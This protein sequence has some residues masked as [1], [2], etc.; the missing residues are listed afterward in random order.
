MIVQFFC[1]VDYRAVN[2]AATVFHR[3]ERSSVHG[4]EFSNPTA[5]CHVVLDD[6]IFVVDIRLIGG[7]S[8]DFEIRACIRGFYHHLWDLQSRL[9]PTWTGVE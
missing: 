4:N 2:N 3:N 9:E 5:D 8:N 1:E 6:L 7:V